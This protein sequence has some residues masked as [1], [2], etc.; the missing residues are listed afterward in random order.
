M[1]IVTSW[2]SFVRRKYVA[3]IVHWSNYHT[4]SEEQQQQK[5]LRRNETNDANEFEMDV[6]VHVCGIAN[7]TNVRV[8]LSYMEFLGRPANCHCSR[9]SIR[10]LYRQHH[11]Q[12]QA[13]TLS[14]RTIS[15]LIWSR[16]LARSLVHATYKRLFRA[17]LSKNPLRRFTALSIW[18]CEKTAT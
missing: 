17:K 7:R 5:K 14:R 3:S 2:H 16:S 12:N 13:R 8:Q 10:R 11:D 6:H 1:P 9:S 15:L 18:S 4:K